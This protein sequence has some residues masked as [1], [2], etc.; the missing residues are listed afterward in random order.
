[1]SVHHMLAYKFLKELGLKPGVPGKKAIN[2]RFEVVPPIKMP[3]IMKENEDVA[4]FMVAEPIATK[5]IAKSIESWN[6]FRPHDGIIIMLCVA[7][8]RT[9][10]KNSRCG[11]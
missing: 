3:G 4:G 2:V 8:S 1:M 10:F 9:S 11:A 7:C 5:A 6:L